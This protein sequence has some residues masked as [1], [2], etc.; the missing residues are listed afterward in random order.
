MKM[1][2]KEMFIRKGD[3]F[4]VNLGLT[5]G[6]EQGGWRPVV[7][8][9]NNIGNKNSQTLIVA[10][11]TTKR[12]GSRMPTHVHIEQDMMG[13]EQDSVVL[14]EQIRTIDKSRLSIEG[15]RYLCRLR[16]TDVEKIN[17]ALETSLGIVMPNERPV[18]KQ[19]E[20]LEKTEFHLNEMISYGNIPKSIISQASIR[21]EIEYNKLK[22]IC[23][24]CRVYIDNYYNKTL[25][26]NVRNGIKV[27]I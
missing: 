13:L 6:S 22:N 10:P 26:I 27:V 21:Y 11:I 14:L 4:F 9:Q 16:K 3:V 12:N 2:Y 7:V 18:L 24:E 1:N 19:L 23:E 25:D 20:I 5:E 15:S 8:V 17:I